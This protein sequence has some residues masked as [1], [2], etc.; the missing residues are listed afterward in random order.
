MPYVVRSFSDPRLILLRNKVNLKQGLARNIAID[1]DKGEFIA[2]QDADDLSLPTRLEH[3]VKFLLFH[4]E[5]DVV[6]SNAYLFNDTGI[7]LGGLVKKGKPT[8]S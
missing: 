3:Q 6:G 1:K 2:V 4:P 8:R 5:V 7:I